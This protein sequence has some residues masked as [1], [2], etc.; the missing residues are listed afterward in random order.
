MVFISTAHGIAKQFIPGVSELVVVYTPGHTQVRRATAYWC[1]THPAF[2][3]TDKPA[4]DQDMK[5]RITLSWIEIL[6]VQL[7]P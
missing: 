4:S 2:P 1:V 5:N 3:G 7:S 6:K